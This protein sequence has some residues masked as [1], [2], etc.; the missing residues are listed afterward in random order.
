MINRLFIFGIGYS[1]LEL[2]KYLLLNGWDVGGS[3]RNQK[4][5]N[6]MI[7]VGI[8]AK[9]FDRDNPLVHPQDILSG[10]SHI[11]TTVPPDDTGDPVF[12][13]H[14]NH[15]NKISSLKWFGY[16]STTSVYGN[17]AGN[18]VDEESLVKPSGERGKK[19]L[20]AENNWHSLMS[21]SFPVHI[22]RVSG[23]YGPN[24]NPFKKIL[25][26]NAYR[27]DNPNHL[28]SRIHVRD[29]SQVLY[30]SMLSPN[31]GRIYNVCDNEP[32]TSSDV[33][34]YAARLLGVDPPPLSALD[35]IEMSEMA[36]SFYSDSKKIR[37]NRIKDELGIVLKFPNY[38]EG[39]DSILE[40]IEN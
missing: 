28:F 9:V 32:A 40:E 14:A 36:K 1:A 25:A 4:K 29:F 37:N 11:L 19:R 26:G 38:R 20:L 7:D 12:D 24:R 27:V 2:A 6:Q 5:C 31:P 33:I 16:I 3:C 18:W 15:L 34:E 10:Y 30:L 21:T 39:L 35:D 23:I 17:H 22:F 13:I 8:D